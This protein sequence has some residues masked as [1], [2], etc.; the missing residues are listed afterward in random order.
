VVAGLGIIESYAIDEHQHLTKTRA[1]NRKIALHAPFAA[2]AD[3]DGTRQPEHISNRR[4]RQ[5]RNLLARDDDYRTAD[6][7]QFDGGRRRRD[8]DRLAVSVLRRHGTCSPED[9]GD[10]YGHESLHPKTLQGVLWRLI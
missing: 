5:R 4:D 7:S 9:H 2:S 1:A 6:P 3:I 10:P 8:D